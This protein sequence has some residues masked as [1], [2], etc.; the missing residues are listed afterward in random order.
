M[1]CGQDQVARIGRVD[2][3]ST[4]HDPRQT[5]EVRILDAFARLVAEHGLAKVNIGMICARSGYPRSVVY[6]HIG[7]KDMLVHQ[8]VEWAKDEFSTA[9]SAAVANRTGS[10]TAT[11]MDMLRALL[12]VFFELMTDLPALFQ[13]F[14]TLWAD[15]VA[16]T[17]PARPVMTEPDGRYRFA[18]AQTVAAGIADGSLE[19]T[20]DPDAYASA[21]LGQLRGISMQVLI[22]PD[23]VDLPGVRAEL[24]RALT[25]MA[26]R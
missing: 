14:I 26:A 5:P 24:E 17:S 2:A 10:A 12:D 23:G 16:E 15:A 7:D 19:A 3:A 11:P 25:R 8:L 18:I 9:Y 13:A 20:T 21:L 4:R 6:Q 22:D 1:T